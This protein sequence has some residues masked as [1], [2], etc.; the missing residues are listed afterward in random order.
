MA[1][2]VAPVLVGYDASELSKAAVR[3]AA[4]LFPERPTMLVTVW[5]PGLATMALTPMGIYD[6]GLPGM[7]PPDP[8]RPRRSIAL[9]ASTPRGS[10]RRE[11]SW[12]ARS[13]SPRSPTPYPTSSTWPTH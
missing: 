3:Q 8:R 7:I 4:D 1:R 9:S 13:G 5:E 12:P 6:A 11:P 2:K 10:P